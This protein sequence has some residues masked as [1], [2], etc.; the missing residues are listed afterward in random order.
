MTGAQLPAIFSLQRQKEI[1]NRQKSY[2]E[3]RIAT[4]PQ[5]LPLIEGEVLNQGIRNQQTNETFA[6]CLLP[7]PSEAIADDKNKKLLIF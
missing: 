5:P 3:K 7:F 4:S 1:G 6:F 2:V